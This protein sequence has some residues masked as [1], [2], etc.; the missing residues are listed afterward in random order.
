MEESR[1][2]ERILGS[3]EGHRR[4]RILKEESKK[5]T[6]NIG[7]VSKDVYN[8][9]AIDKALRNIVWSTK[10]SRKVVG[11]ECREN[12]GVSRKEYSVNK[13]GSTETNRV[14]N[15]TMKQETDVA[16]LYE[17]S[18]RS[19]DYYIRR[20]TFD[21]VTP[22]DWKEI[23]CPY[24]F[25]KFAHDEVCFRKKGVKN[26]T[27]DH[28][29]EKLRKFWVTEYGY[30]NLEQVKG[31]KKNDYEDKVFSLKD[32]DMYDEKNVQRGEGGFIDRIS[33]L[34][35]LDI[36]KDDTYFKLCP[37]CHNKLPTYYGQYSVITIS[38]LGVTK[39][40]KTVYLTELLNKLQETLSR[41]EITMSD[42]FVPANA[43]NYTSFA[44]LSQNAPL[45]LNTTDFQQPI[46]VNIEKTVA[47]N[48]K[49]GKKCLAT[50]VFYDIAGEKCI[51]TTDLDKYAKFLRKS[52]GIIMLMDPN[53]FSKMKDVS[54]YEDDSNVETILKAIYEY[55]NRK[56]FDAFMA[57]SLSKSDKIKSVIEHDT[58]LSC[59]HIKANDEI[60]D[61]ICWKASHKGFYERSYGYVRGGMIYLMREIDPE[62]SVRR[63]L[64]DMFEDASL[65]SIS[66]L[67]YDPDKRWQ[68]KIEES[69]N[70]LE[71]MELKLER[72]EEKE[73]R[74]KIQEDIK[75]MEKRFV[76]MQ[77]DRRKGLLPD[78]PNPCRVEEPLLWILY[79]L[80]IIDAVDA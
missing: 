25:E 52:Q 21:K 50:L 75:N 37:H 28:I 19:N 47:R 1:T 34:Y 7:E 27:P 60:F 62:G 69:K 54:S 9:E 53:Q 79:K 45:P 49:S 51:K 55:N 22:P 18:R 15:R 80:G 39:S 46:F 73:K 32:K 5:R 35:D 20:H 40:G 70:N 74:I 10:E 3:I 2:R 65:F 12:E 67:G 66:A 59:T 58:F 17:T 44:N 63:R 13:P 33:G 78:A 48:G 29:D 41:L 8:N 31:M 64:I 38:I 6:G 76:E 23:T 30:K 26:D 56:P 61:D 77:D 16:S 14:I 71:K 68:E 24:C 57:A 4:E 11:M 36:Y 72:S 42:F 43:P